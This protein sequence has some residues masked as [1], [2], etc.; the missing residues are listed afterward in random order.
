[1][2]RAYFNETQRFRQWWIYLIIAGSLIAW[3][4]GVFTSITAVEEEKATEDYILIL[5]SLA[6]IL[7]VFMIFALRLV[8]RV[9]NDG[10][11]FQFKPLQFKEKHIKPDEINSWEVR[12]YS[13]IKEYGGWGI[14]AGGKKHG[15]AYNISGNMGLQ[16]Y[17]K[18]GKK[19]L[20]GTQ[21]P[22]EMQKAMESMLLIR[23]RL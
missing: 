1:M 15:K 12:K 13:P 2:S 23:L 10:V 18:N 7:L 9:R 4:Y 11:Y 6:P 17:L 16:L 19:L 20:I 8:T 5:T 22:R 21:K 3:G 14:R